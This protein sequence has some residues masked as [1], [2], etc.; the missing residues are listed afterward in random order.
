MLNAPQTGDS[1]TDTSRVTVSDRATAAASPAAPRC[2]SAISVPV[3]S[4]PRLPTLA[5]AK[6]PC[7][8]GVP[9]LG[10][11]PP[12]RP[13][14]YRLEFDD[15]TAIAV[16]GRGLI[17]RA[18][19]AGADSDVEHLIQLVDDTLS[20]SRTHL[21]FGIGESGLWIRDCAS[22][23][24]SHIEVD[25]QRNPIEAAV[26]VTVPSGCVIHIGAR[27]VRVQT[28]SGRAVIGP[29]TVEW[30]VATHIGAA[31][32]QNQDAYCAEAPVFVVADG[33]G[34]HTAGQLASREVVESLRTLTG[35]LQVTREMFTARLVEARIRLGQIPACDGPPP[36]TTLSGVIVTQSDDDDPYW[37]VVNVGDSR[38]YRSDADG[39][40]QITVDH[41]VVRE[42]IDAGVVTAADA[43]SHRLGNLLTRAVLAQIDHLPD[44][45]LLP[46][47]RGD[48]ILVCSDGLTRELDDPS[49]ARVL[50]AA[51]D[52]LAAADEL[53]NT[54]AD[55]G[56]R[57]DVTALVVDAV[58]V[59][60]A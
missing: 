13:A 45:W 1:T 29:A 5:L 32:Q 40:S 57:D 22:T 6:S 49:I 20:V 21:E 15:G 7:A 28:T 34:G 25:G 44:V 53:V 52:P 16:R 3:A 54:A 59:G 41:S 36:G 35:D 33:M 37:M 27:R 8:Q 43:P 31:R 12:A 2:R 17:G 14:R 11:S 39:L 4:S 26:P 10:A 9:Q 60:S 50:R 24:G 23:N 18:P 30:G 55:A 19:T 48:R 42:L 56:C 51:A 47:S 58:T 38:T 46:I